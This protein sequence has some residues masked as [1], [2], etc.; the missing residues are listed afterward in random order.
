M[1]FSFVE[2]QLNKN[3]KTKTNYACKLL[4]N[5]KNYTVY[6]D[7]YDIPIFNQKFKFGIGRGGGKMFT[8]ETFKILST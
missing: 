6:T 3:E 2:G 5:F 7:D 1:C 4:L 8:I